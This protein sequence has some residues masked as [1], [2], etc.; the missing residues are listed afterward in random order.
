MNINCKLPDIS[1]NYIVVSSK[2]FSNTNIYLDDPGRIYEVVKFNWF[3]V[4]AKETL[5]FIFIFSMTSTSQYFYKDV[6]IF[7][8]INFME[9][10][11]LNGN[12]KSI[13]C[14]P[15]LAHLPRYHQ[16]YQ[17]KGTEKFHLLED[18]KNR[19]KMNIKIKLTKCNKNDDN[20]LIFNGKWRRI[21]ENWMTFFWNVKKKLYLHTHFHIKLH[22]HTH[23]RDF[24]LF[25]I[26]F[27]TFLVEWF[28]THKKKE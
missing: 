11:K 19:K 10:M 3:K 23:I 21:Y 4:H 17:K 8:I 18:N 5:I 24:I 7:K 28:Y 9:I 20:I 13:L 6:D 2:N 14:T 22:T 26:Q 1:K 27:Y 15:T 16:M 25:F 12:A